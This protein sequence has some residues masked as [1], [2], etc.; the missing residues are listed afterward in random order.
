LIFLFLTS[1]K[2]AQRIFFLHFLLSTDQ[3]DFFFLKDFNEESALTIE[4]EYKWKEFWSW[5]IDEWRKS[6]A[7]SSLLI[8]RKI[9]LRKNI[10][11]KW[12]SNPFPQHFFSAQIVKYCEKFTGILDKYRHREKGALIEGSNLKIWQT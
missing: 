12:N 5:I 4:K 2:F 8:S 9:S 1:Q 3:N 11:A 7:G 10:P 6:K